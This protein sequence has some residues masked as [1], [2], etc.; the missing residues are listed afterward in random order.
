MDGQNL[1][2]S[3]I[4]CLNAPPSLCFC[5]ARTGLH[6]SRLKNK[7]DA[8]FI[9]IIQIFKNE[10]YY[11]LSTPEVFLKSF[12]RKRQFYLNQCTQRFLSNKKTKINNR[13]DLLPQT[14]EYQ[15]LPGLFNKKRE[16]EMD[17]IKLINNDHCIKLID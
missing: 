5:N 4:Y 3:N 14:G 12:E 7:Q 1:Q 15:I 10:I 16:R 11:F 6:Y 9:F 2:D 17:P 8:C 13:E